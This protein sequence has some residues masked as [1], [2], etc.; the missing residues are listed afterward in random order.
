MIV[1]LSSLT[2]VFLSSLSPCPPLPPL[3]TGYLRRVYG[4]FTTWFLSPSLS[5]PYILCCQKICPT[6]QTA[7]NS[8]GSPLRTGRRWK[9][10]EGRGR[11]WVRSQWQEDLSV[12]TAHWCLCYQTGGAD[13]GSSSCGFLPSMDSFPPFSSQKPVFL[14]NQ[15]QILSKC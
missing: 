5:S 8:P 10:G 11:R 4:V 2:P 6:S 9:E 1:Q 13:G 7:G 3:M 14:A 15:N 12:M